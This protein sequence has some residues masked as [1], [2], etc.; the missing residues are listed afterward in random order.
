MSRRHWL[1]SFCSSRLLARSWRGLGQQDQETTQLSFVALRQKMSADGGGIRA[2]QDKERAQE[3]WM[4]CWVREACTGRNWSGRGFSRQGIWTSGE[5]RLTVGAG[6]V[7]AV[8]G[9]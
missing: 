1:I 7:E 6:L 8:G 5:V 4:G 3:V 2:T 9:C